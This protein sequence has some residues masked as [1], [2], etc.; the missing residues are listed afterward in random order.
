M[1]SITAQVYHSLQARI[2]A[3]TSITHCVEDTG[4]L[5]DEQPA[6]SYP[7]ALI[8]I[9]VTDFRSL[10]QNAQTATLVISIT[11][12]LEPHSSTANNTP[13]VYKTK[14]LSY[15]VVEQEVHTALQGFAPTYQLL[16]TPANPDADPPTAAVYTDSLANVTGRLDRL[17]S[18]PNR[19]RAD[20]RI[21]T[22]TYTLGYEDYS[23]AIIPIYAPATPVITAAIVTP[24][25][26]LID[27]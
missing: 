2:I 14:G 20:L 11:I 12:V 15:Y 23:T 16:V 13:E 1:N 9:E 18:A 8:G 10:A 17:R 27:L 26:L 25:T 21:R 3:A 6:I 24:D 22:L 4:Q 7:C 19:T 5:L